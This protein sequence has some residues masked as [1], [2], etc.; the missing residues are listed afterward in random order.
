MTLIDELIL[1]T[2]ITDFQPYCHPGTR[3]SLLATVHKSKELKIFRLRKKGLE[4]QYLTKLT[5][6]QVPVACIVQRDIFV[7]TYPTHLEYIRVDNKGKDNEVV[8]RINP[9]LWH[10]P[11]DG[12]DPLPTSNPDELGAQGLAMP[13]FDET[14]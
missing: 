12:A 5:L 10:H 13:L 3:R 9:L 4:Y 2:N 11:L 1:E 8:T 14:T 7:L 6:E